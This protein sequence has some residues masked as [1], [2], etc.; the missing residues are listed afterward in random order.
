MIQLYPVRPSFPQLILK[1]NL[2]DEWVGVL[3]VFAFSFSF[4]T[5]HSD[6]YWGQVSA[7]W[8]TAFSFL[9]SQLLH[10]RIG[11]GINRTDRRFI[12]GSFT[13]YC[14]AREWSTGHP[15]DALGALGMYDFD[16]RL[17][18]RR[19]VVG[20]SYSMDDMITV[21]HGWLR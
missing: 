16:L 21:L 10:F 13:T 7:W 2:G 3:K 17:T 6:Q 12:D 1:G 19:G 20:N 8:H 4:P 15:P 9:F 11:T 14:M 18:L 5:S